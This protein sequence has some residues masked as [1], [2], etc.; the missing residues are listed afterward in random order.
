M[1]VE[2]AGPVAEGGEDVVSLVCRLLEGNPAQLEGVAWQQDGAGLEGGQGCTNLAA[3]E[4]SSTEEESGQE[5]EGGCGEGGEARLVLGPASR[6]QAGSYTC[7][8]RNAAG[9]GPQSE[10]AN[11]TVHCKLSLTVQL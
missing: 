5:E 10:P 9:E 1:V 11:L 4:L 8:G 2:P 3:L 6:E 7:T